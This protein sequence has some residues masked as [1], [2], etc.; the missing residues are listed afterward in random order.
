MK[1]ILLVLAVVLGF[2]AYSGYQIFAAEDIVDDFPTSETLQCPMHQ[3]GTF[4]RSQMRG[5]M[6]Q[7]MNGVRRQR[8]NQDNR[9]PREDCPCLDDS[10]SE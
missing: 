10:D 8:L 3:D 9:T 5:R 1:K 7:M 6:G 2:G 4:T